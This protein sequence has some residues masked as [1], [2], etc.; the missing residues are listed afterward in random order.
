MNRVCRPMLDK[1]VIMFID[2]ILIY[3][4]SAKDY[5]THLRK[6]LSM[7]KQEKLYAKFSKCEFWLRE[8]PKNPIEIRSF[9]GLAGYY[10]RFIQDFAKIASSLTKFTKKNAKFEWGEDQEIAFQILKQRLNQALVLVLPEGNDDMEVYCDASL[11]GLGCVLMQRGRVIAYACR[12]LKKHQEEYPTHDLELAVVLDLVKD[13]EI[14]YHPGQDNVVANALSRK[15]RHD[16]LLVKS[17]QMPLEIPVWKWEKITMDLIMKLPKTPRQ[18][19][20]IRAEYVPLADIVVDEK[21]GHVEE[22]VEILDTMVKKL[23]RKE[24]LLFKVRWKHRKGLDYM[25][26]PEEELIKYYPDFHKE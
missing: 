25:W 26:E 24:I 17:P 23:R 21:L 16:S 8:Q 3:S 12:K 9:L 14:L 4:K 18:C 5:E 15:T 7:L 19:D 13:C 10:Y 2:D 1:S 6:V 11:N 22:P 20:A